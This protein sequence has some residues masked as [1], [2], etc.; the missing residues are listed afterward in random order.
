MPEGR[1]SLT[2]NGGFVYAVPVT[3]TFA[4]KSLVLIVAFCQE[5]THQQTPLQIILA[6]HIIF[7]GLFSGR[8]TL[9]D[10]YFYSSLEIKIKLKAMY[11]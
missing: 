6:T 4:I 5:Y 1:N 7:Q 11:K 9:S 10:H 8:F 2:L 3:P